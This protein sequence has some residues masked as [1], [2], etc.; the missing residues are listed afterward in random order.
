M[1]AP[2]AT[3]PPL[4]PALCAVRQMSVYTCL[5]Y[6]VYINCADISQNVDWRDSPDCMLEF[7]Q[8]LRLLH[9]VQV[10]TV[11]ILSKLR[12]ANFVIFV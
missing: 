6:E 11:P 3:P 5:L 7:V 1:G 9:F 8:V 10:R 4:D 2:C 12:P